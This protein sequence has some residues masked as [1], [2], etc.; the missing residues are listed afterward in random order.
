MKTMRKAIHILSFIVL[1]PF[2]SCV[3]EKDMEREDVQAPVSVLATKS[4]NTAAN[5]L[6]GTLLVKF[7]NAAVASLEKGE[8]VGEISELCAEFSAHCSNL[9][10]CKGTVL[11]KKHNLNRWFVLRFDEAIDVNDVAA[12]AAE[13]P[14]VETIQF[15]TA[16]ERAFGSEATA[17]TPSTK[18]GSLMPF[19]DPKLQDQWHYI[20]LGDVSV[21]PTSRVG[22]DVNVKD[23]WNLTTGDSRIIVAI[24]DEAV[25]YNHPDLQAN[26]WVNEGEIAD[27]GIDDD[28]NGYIDDV[29][30]FNFLSP[31]DK[32]TGT[33]DVLP[34]SWD[35]TNDSGH[36]THVAGTI[37]AVN[38]NGMGVCG[39]AGGRTG[40]GD[41]VRIMTCQLF[42]GNATAGMEN[43]ALAYHYAADNGAS[44]LQCSFG[45][46]GGQLASD[47]DFGSMYGAEEEAL[48]YFIDQ[49]VANNNPA[50]GNFVIFASGNEGYPMSGYPAAYNRYISVAAIGPD[51][52]PTAYTNY[53]PGTNISA[54]GGEIAINST[55]AEPQRAQILSTLPKELGKGEYGYM[56]GTS[57]A[58][59]HVSGVVALGLSYALKLGKTFTHEEFLSMIYTSVNNVD[60][61]VETCEKKINGIPF[62]LTPYLYN[63]GTGSIDAWRLL[64][65]VEGTPNMLV[66]TGKDTKVA[67]NQFFGPSATNLTYTKI[68][69]SEQAREALGV[70][71]EPYI[72]YGKFFIKCT[73]NGSAKISISAIAG[74]DTYAG[75]GLSGIGGT[76]FTREISVLSREAGV[77]ENGG[78]L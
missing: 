15:N 47:K 26:M 49:P 17:W 60:F 22:A 67:L 23:A 14:V 44:I 32:E 58:C 10:P 73:K 11:E 54:P 61:Y 9:F 63:T 12:K 18:S 62:D 56:Q 13:L 42:S 20:N 45:Q 19:N 65:Q 24:C 35:K 46:S 5:A 8:S 38:N 78:W 59:P 75:Q 71:G 69:I 30:G 66:Q 50:G 7:S 52:L 40:N 25:K 68:E 33:W 74:G 6:P 31:Y 36:G 2:V 16:L 27:N 28:G 55:S 51:F 48:N 21:A 37:A 43:R 4:V 41:G 77:A 34:L 64:M 70:E 29:H 76:E 39:I 3:N 57:M 72:K 1:L 53:G